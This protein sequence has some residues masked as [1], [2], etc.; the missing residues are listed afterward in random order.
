MSKYASTDPTTG[1]I[2]AKFE[3]ESDEQVMASLSAADAAYRTWR[4]AEV[5]ERA[6]VL[7]RVA[8]LH[9]ERETELAELMTLEMGKP[10]A[11]ARG[12]V[13]LSASIFEYYATKGMDLLADEEL[14]I[15]GSGRALVRTAPIGA[16]VGVMP[17]NFPYYQVARFVAPNLLL[18]NTILLKHA[19]NCPQQALAVEAMLRDAGSPEG[20]YRNI[21]AS[22]DQ[23]ADLIA[24]PRIQ[25]VSLTGSERAGSIIGQLAGKYMKKAVLELG[26]SD[27]FLVL[28]GADLD[29][30]VAAAVPGRFGNAGQAC[31]SSKRMIVDASVW[32][33]FLDG[34]VSAA[35]SWSMG[36]P[37]DPATRLGPMSSIGGRDEIAEQ[38]AD[39]VSKGATVHL[40][41]TVPDGDGAYYPATVLSGVTPDMRAYR[42]ELFGPVAVLHKVDSTDAAID[43]ANDSPFGLG[44]A[45]FT[46]DDSEAAYVADRLD[47]G[48]VGINTTIKS[49]PDMPFGGVKT[50]GIGRELGRFGL[51][52]FA[53]KKLVRTL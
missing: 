19:S 35:Q 49:A 39:A 51:D 8:D 13:K 33:E 25:G 46:T 21:F 37:T 48:M 3:T 45:V 22:S 17:W 24:D 32:D 6:S 31:T 52:E 50:S 42:E 41:G 12:E 34:F 1:T 7:Q 28:A 9:R 4:T 43:L 29:D 44:S 53:N 40:G 47:V 23:I 11:Q 16:L 14:D 36:D 2:V 15:A 30:A 26:G 5:A 38:V 20:V 18:G 10:I 27:P